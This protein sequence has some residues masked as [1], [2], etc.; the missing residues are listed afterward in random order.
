MEAQKEAKMNMYHSVIDLCEDNLVVVALVPAFETSYNSFKTT[1][2]AIESGMDTL[3]AQTGGYA[4]SKKTAKRNLGTMGS[5]I[6]GM[7]YA[8]ASVIADETLQEAMRIPFTKIGKAL[9]DEVVS[10]CNNI[11]STANG[12]IASL[13]DYG[14][15]APLLATFQT[16]ISDYASKAP[17]PKQSKNNKKMMREQLNEL[18]KDADGLLETQMDKLAVIFLSNGNAEFEGQ[19]RAARVIV[20]PGTYSTVLKIL[21]MNSMN[22]EPLKNVKSYRDNTATFKK[23]SDHGYITYKDIEEG[24]H[25]FVLKHKLFYDLEVNNIM[26]SHGK[27][28]EVNALMV[29]IAGGNNTVVRQ[30]DISP[31]DTGSFDGSLIQTT[32]SST[33]T[34][35]IGPNPLRLSA[36]DTQAAPAGPVVWD[37]PAGTV[38]KTAEE[39]A[40]LVGASEINH[41]IK[42]Q[43]TG[44]VLSHFKITFNNLA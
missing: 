20:D 1:V 33:V 4:M 30:G 21:V 7:V 37:V 14:V 24:A 27:K 6:A 32:E 40:A 26:I 9:D 38:T 3:E 11:Y 16:A 43:N 10:I 41:F 5:G 2:S 31:G 25:S 36:N 17:K 19:Y 23:S 13:A 28:I 29:P 39:F 18:F 44:A 15:T 22:N 35:E 8:Y 34:V 12:L 42:I